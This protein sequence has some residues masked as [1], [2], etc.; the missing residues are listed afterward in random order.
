[1]E[2]YILIYHFKDEKD[3]EFFKSELKKKFPKHK[4]DNTQE[5]EYFAFSARHQPAVVDEINTIAHRMGIS[6]KDYIALYYTRPSNSDDINRE[7]LL[8]SDN[9]IETDLKNI[10]LERHRDN[11]IELMDY[12]FL[13]ERNN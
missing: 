3:N 9:L 5:L 12:D 1:M 8:G 7:M 13:A 2:N 6:T 4:I 10:S 11:L